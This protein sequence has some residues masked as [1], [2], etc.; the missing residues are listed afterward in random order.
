[1]LIEPGALI[2]AVELGAL[3]HK[4]SQS[5][6]FEG[7]HARLDLDVVVRIVRDAPEIDRERFWHELRLCTQLKHAGVVR[8][9]DFGEY[10]G[11]RYVISAR[12]RGRSLADGLAQHREPL[13]ER[14][15]LTLLTQASLAIG[16]CHAAGIGHR[17]LQ[18]QHLRM[19]ARGDLRITDFG[20]AAS[21][22]S[23]PGADH[24]DARER[25]HYLPPECAVPDASI[26]HAADLFSLGVI[27][28]ELAFQRLPYAAWVSEDLADARS[29][30]CAPLDLPTHCSSKLVGII[31]RLIHPDPMRRIDCMEALLEHFPQESSG[32]SAPGGL[33]FRGAEPS[34]AAPAPPPRPE[35]ETLPLEL[36]AV[37]RFLQRWFGSAQSRRA[38]AW[39]LHTSLR[40]RFLVWGLL[41]GLAAA[42]AVAFALA[43]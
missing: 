3:L 40:E 43:R 35:P 32:W 11:L 24:G 10:D 25:L 8:A 31:Q 17:N 13:S 36:M 33:A 38:G 5:Y 42:S 6:L 34:V 16:A 19:D 20:L 1:M 29:I 7:R 15:I 27:A 22:L 28:Y 37:A 4:G 9:I 26:P 30:P 2:G 14:A 23:S 21:I 39:V 41:L 12:V 18:P